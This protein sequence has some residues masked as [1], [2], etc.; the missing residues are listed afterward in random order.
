VVLITGFVAT[1]FLLRWLGEERFGA[2]RAANDWFVYLGLLEFGVGGALLA[3]LAQ[4]VGRGD[5]RSIRSTLAVGIRAYLWISAAMVAA[6]MGL[7]L[8]ITRLVPVS[9]AY[10]YDLQRGAFIGVFAF[11]LLPFGA[12]Y[13]ALAE[14]RQ[15][16]YWI[17]ALLLLQALSIT[18][19][20]LVLAYLGWGITGQFVA[21]VFGALLFNAPLIWDGIKRYPGLLRSA[22]RDTPDPEAQR[23]LRRLNTPT[24]I[25]NVAGRFS[26]ETDNIIVALML[27]PVAVVPLFLTQKLIVMVQGQLTNVGNASWAALAELHFQG[28]RELFNRRLVELTSLVA[29]FGI[30]GLVPVAVYNGYFVRLWVGQEHYAGAWVS[31]VVASNAYVRAFVTLW[32]WCFGGTARTPMLIRA[33][34]AE[35]LINITA[36]VL[37]TWQLGIIGPLL[38]TSIGFAAVSLWYL[39]KLLKE[40]FGTPPDQLFKAITYPLLLGVPYTLGVWWVASTFEPVG[41]IQLGVQIAASPFG[42]LALW[43]LLMLDRDQRARVAERVRK[44]IG[45]QK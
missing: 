33:S 31:I 28:H 3:L 12:P 13:K 4:A 16:G 21:L 29:V 40:V 23:G 26:F 38:G 10:T 19:L 36:S 5:A 42:Y 39:P 34:V 11:L 32:G 43:W 9:A 17:H 18:G 22:I 35:G 27:G 15:Q 37:L 45:R 7:V 20:A 41:W 25:Y 30:A 8:F 24:F 2:F 44:I 14:S 6:G 1:P